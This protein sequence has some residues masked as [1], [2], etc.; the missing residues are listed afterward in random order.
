MVGGHLAIRKTKERIG[1]DFMWPTI[2]RDVI[3]YRKTC[4]VCQKRA[5]ITSRNRV[6]MEGVLSLQNQFSAILTLML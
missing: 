3:E 1:L 4:E 5:P 6:P 2:N